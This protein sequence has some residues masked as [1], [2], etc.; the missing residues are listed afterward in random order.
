MTGTS[1]GYGRVNKSADTPI[2]KRGISLTA[3][4]TLFFIVFILGLFAIIAITS[5]QQFNDAAATT[6]SRLGYP[7]L[8]RASS[9]ID[10]DAFEKLSKTLDP[11]DPFY[12]ETRLKLLALKEETQCLYLYTMSK[13]TDTIHKFIIDG[14]NPDD[15]GFSH[16]GADEDIREYTSAYLLTYETKSPQSSQMNLLSSWGWLISSYMPIFNSSGDMVGV[17]GC[18]FEAQTIFDAIYSRILQQIVYAVIFIFIGMILYWFM[19]RA[20]TK[21]NRILMDLTNKAEQASRS[22]SNFLARTSHEIRTP[23]NAIIGLSELA[24]REY[25]KPK[26]LEYIAGIKNAG[27]G[28]MAIINDILD[29]SQ[30]ESGAL[31]LHPAPYQTAS[32]LNDALAIIRV[33]LSEKSLKLVVA[34][35]PD[36]PESMIGDAGRVRQIMLNL[37]S[38]AVKYTENGFIKFSASGERLHENAAR[39]TFIV[40]DSGIGIKSEDLPKLFGEFSRVD[41]KRN[42]NI[43]GTGLGLTI[44]RSLCRAMGGD[45]TVRSEYGRGSVF[46]AML[47]QEVADWKP[48]GELSEI[49]MNRD[50]EP[51]ATF[52]APEAEVLVVDDFHSNLLVAEGLLAPYGMRVFTCLSGLEAVKLVR[53]RFFDLVLMDHMMPEMDGVEAIHAIRAIS[54]KRFRTLPVIALTANAVSGMREMFLENG[55]DDFLS[56]PI[57]TAKLDAT[58]KKWLPEGKRR[59]PP[60]DA[61]GNPDSAPSA[62]MPVPEIEGV[63]AASGM[64]RIGGSKS[65]YLELLAMFCRDAQAGSE[66]LGKTPDHASLRSFTTLVHA[67]KSAAANIG[68]DGLS[69]TAASLEMAGRETDM[70]VIRDKLPA[71]REELAGLTARIGAVLESARNGNGEEGA[72]PEMTKTLARLRGALQAKDF[73][74]VDAALARLQALPLPAKTRAAVSEAADSILVADFGKAADRLADLPN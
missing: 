39:L 10:G 16:L 23:M 29:F 45:I 2:T 40:E 60:Q 48:M 28:L 17:I 30:I 19:L 13:Y 53:E 49:S 64:A 66:L 34:V 50:D 4:F 72:G 18:D 58:L 21:Q 73:D 51:C 56:K 7:I 33:R 1:Q 6:A 22:K 57:E 52:I 24:Q 3:Q 8:K 54:G 65:R 62:E 31:P 9:L 20:I 69:Q 41:E 15:E 14:G 38:N 42:I 25:G 5:I 68:A 47:T 44:T 74:A 36:L 12:E 55:F 46:T 71:F 27:A 35:S 70:P 11:L 32:L 63:D 59:K 43:E 61:S 26:A 37:L 67:L